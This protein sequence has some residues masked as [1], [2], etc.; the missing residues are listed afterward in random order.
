MP[1]RQCPAE[2]RSPAVCPDASV[3]NRM[4][5]APPSLGGL[6]LVIDLNQIDY[7]R[8]APGGLNSVTTLAWP[9]GAR[10]GSAAR[11]IGARIG[12]AARLIGA[13][14]LEVRGFGSVD[15][16]SVVV[17][18]PG[19]RAWQ[20]RAHTLLFYC[21]AREYVREHKSSQLAWLKATEPHVLAACSDQR[22]PSLQCT[23]KARTHPSTP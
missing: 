9:I 22:G 7:H 2:D 20:R 4:L 1:K 12:S 21:S 14:Q 13:R 10:I 6:P 16:C 19:D 3:S 17:S 11:P 8:S 15:A 18:V 23:H 5:G